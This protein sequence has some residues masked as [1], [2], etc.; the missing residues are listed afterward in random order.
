MLRK[1]FIQ[2]VTQAAQKKKTS[3]PSRSWTYDLLFTT[4]EVLPLSYRRLI[5][6]GSTH[7]IWEGR[8]RV[9]RGGLKKCFLT[10]WASVWSK[11]NNSVPPLDLPLLIIA[12]TT[13]CFLVVFV[14]NSMVLY[15]II[16]THITLSWLNGCPRLNQTHFQHLLQVILVCWLIT[17]LLYIEQCIFIIGLD[18]SIVSHNP[19]YAHNMF[20][21]NG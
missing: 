3:T 12:K 15:F 16:H 5:S 21:K 13:N 8:G 17:L 18:L 19:W 9:G 2:S 1:M 6:G 7:Y 4:P 10:L 11:N 20:Y 14:C